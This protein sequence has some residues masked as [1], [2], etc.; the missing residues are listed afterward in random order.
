[1]E[2]KKVVVVVGPT[3]SGKTN[4]AIELAKKIDGEIVSADSMQIYKYM[5]IGTAKPSPEEM[6]GIKHYMM[7]IIE[8]DADFSVAKYKEMALECVEKIIREK[9]IPIIVGGT[10]LYV[11]SIIDNIEFSEIITDWEYRS[12]LQERAEREGSETLFRELKEV[13]PEASMKIHPNDTRRIIRALEVYKYTGK[14]ISYHQ[15]QS[16]LNPPAYNFLVIGLAMERRELYRRIDTRVDRMIENGLINEVKSLLERGV[17]SKCTA[18]QG[19]G[20]KEM[21]EHLDGNKTLEE[22]IETIKRD[23]RRYAKRQLTW[24]RRDQRIFWV[25]A[26]ED[27]K[28]NVKKIF[29]YLEANGMFM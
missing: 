26:L 1:M 11:N 20:Y 16:R 19:L 10:G 18:M 5:D 14:P 8:P 22:V 9:K 7:D 24:F 17:D 21:V 12:Q 28:E 2:N 29:I 25:D 6:Q 27:Q 23:S 13:D 15:K 3:A 4:M